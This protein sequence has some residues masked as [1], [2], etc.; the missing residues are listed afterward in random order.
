MGAMDLSVGDA[1][2]RI[3]CDERSRILVLDDWMSPRNFWKQLLSGAFIV[4]VMT[5]LDQDMMQK[6]LTCRTLREAQK[7]M[8]SYGVA[9]LP[10]NML[11]LALGVLLAQHF[12][13]A[14]ISIERG[15]ELLPAFVGA[16]GTFVAAL[17]TIG[18]MAASFSSADSALTSLTTSFC[19]DICHRPDDER[20]RKQCHVL[21]CLL[22]AVFILLIHAVNSGSLIDTI[23][24]IVSYTYGPLL[25]LFAYGLFTKQR[26]ADRWVPYVCVAS[27]LLCYAIDWFCQRQFDYHFGYELLMLNGLLTFLGLCLTRMTGSKS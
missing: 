18:L 12:E 27:P 10:A 7:N 13:A 20:L 26:V 4:V 16:Q 17:F 21:M 6:N 23:Y 19:I 25:G 9:F 2:N 3:L 11:F 1:V 24:M 14:A 5:G 15:D 22:F 8:C